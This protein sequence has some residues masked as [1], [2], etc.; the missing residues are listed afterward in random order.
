MYSKAMK[1]LCWKDCSNSVLIAVF[2]TVKTG[3]QLASCSG[4]RYKENVAY[5]QNIILCNHKK[6][7]IV[8]VTK[9]MSP[10]GVMLLKRAVL[11]SLIPM[12]N[13]KHLT[14]QRLRGEQW[15]AAAGVSREVRTERGCSV[16]QTERLSLGVQ[17]H[18]RTTPFNTSVLKYTF[19]RREDFECS[20]HKEMINIW[21]KI[22]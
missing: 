10:E 1:L 17:L 15:L 3:N 13:C 11:H 8:T 21:V 9:R 5:K 4:C 16:L 7:E 18:S 2:S 19:A 14:S 6:D 12:W 22:C 20:H